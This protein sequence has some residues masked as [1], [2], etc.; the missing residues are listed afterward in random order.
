MSST[1]DTLDAAR[2]MKAAGIDQTQA[3]AI[4]LQMG[5]ASKADRDELVTRVEF[6]RGLLIHSAVIIAAMS[7]MKFFG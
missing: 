2:E 5:R 1:F 7:P 6:Y 3:E 4:A